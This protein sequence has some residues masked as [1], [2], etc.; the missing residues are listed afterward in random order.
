MI[1]VEYTE[2][3]SQP[4]TRA[5]VVASDQNPYSL[6]NVQEA[7]NDLRPSL[8]LPAK[9]IAASHHYV[10][11]NIQDSLMYK[12]VHDDLGLELIEYPLD[13]E[14]TVTEMNAYMSNTSNTW[15]YTVVPAGFTYPQGV[16]YEFLDYV[17]MQGEPA[18]RA[19]GETPQIDDEDYDLVIEKAMQNNGINVAS[20]TRGAAWYPSA[21]IKFVEDYNG[22]TI[23][24]E[25]VKVR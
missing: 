4:R 13:I 2:V 22:N 24:L 5:A 1:P 16:S 20:L 10:R 17:Y 21:T 23:N 15:Y 9:T 18:T 6:S 12:T 8:G 14:L 3:E 25:G 11:F 7:Y 19:P